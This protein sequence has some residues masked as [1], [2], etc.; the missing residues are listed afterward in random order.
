MPRRSR[1]TAAKAAVAVVMVRVEPAPIARA[2]PYKTAGPGA[3]AAAKLPRPTMAA[4]KAISR[5]E[6]RFSIAH[7][8]GR[9]AS[10]RPKANTDN[11]PPSPVVEMSSSRPMSG[12]RGGRKKAAA[13]RMNTP[14]PTPAR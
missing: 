7:P 6:R 8:A 12:S 13:V 2:A 10:N 14:R 5:L 3:A 11:R 4:A 1:G 9:S